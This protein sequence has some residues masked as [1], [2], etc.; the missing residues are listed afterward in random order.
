[1][2]YLFL[3]MTYCKIQNMNNLIINESKF[4]S[5]SSPEIF[6]QL[7]TID[8]SSKIRLTTITFCVLDEKKNNI[9]F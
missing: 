6:E 9:N 1:M 2:M 7:S 8:V 5:T 4:K 3:G